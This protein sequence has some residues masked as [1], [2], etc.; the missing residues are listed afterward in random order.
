MEEKRAATKKIGLIIVIS[1]IVLLLALCIWYFSPSKKYGEMTLC[2][3][4][5]EQIQAVIDVG[6]YRKPFS[7]IQCRGTI[8]VDGD[9]YQ[10]VDAEY[11]GEGTAT[12]WFARSTSIQS[13]YEDCLFLPYALHN[14]KTK[15]FAAV[16]MIVRK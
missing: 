16:C 15:D 2:S 4:E 14:A 1:G 7:S 3:L 5:G 8:T 9:A 10:S 13:L 12:P 11:H 6:W